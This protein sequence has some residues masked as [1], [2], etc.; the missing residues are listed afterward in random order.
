MITAK[1]RAEDLHA[2]KG[3][4]TFMQSKSMREV[5]VKAR[6]IKPALAL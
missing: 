4:K 2:V 6:C 3:V 1:P 5:V